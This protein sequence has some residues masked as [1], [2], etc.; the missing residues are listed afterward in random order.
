MK[1]RLADLLDVPALQSLLDSLYAS[2]KIPSAIIDN[3]GKV[4]AGSGW[5]DACTKFHRVHPDVEKLCVESDR[6]AV[7]RID[8]ARP[9]VPYTCPQGLTD[10]ATPLVVGGA[11]VAN[12]FTGQLFLAPPD[13]GFFRSQ[14]GRYGWD[15]IGR[16]SCRERV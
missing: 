13:I 14:A 10:S 3:E 6:R 9:A 15:E 5:Q 4:L 16:A 1:H 11:H 8:E 7:E 12:V 2:S